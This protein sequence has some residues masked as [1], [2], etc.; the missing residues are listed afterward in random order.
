M[1]RCADEANR[2]IGIQPTKNK[3]KSHH[4]TLVGIILST[5][6]FATVWMSAWFPASKAAIDAIR[7]ASEVKVKAK[8]VRGGWLIGKLFGRNRIS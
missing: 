6:S 2:K 3:P 8:D 5:L 4:L 1:S 7:G